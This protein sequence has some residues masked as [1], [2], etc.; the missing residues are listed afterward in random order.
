MAKAK[1]RRPSDCKIKVGEKRCTGKYKLSYD[2]AAPLFTCNKCQDRDTSWKKFYDDYLQL[3]SVKENWD[4]EKNNVTCIIGF[5]CHM[6]RELFDTDYVFVPNN[7]NP[8]SSKEIREAWKLL[9]TFKNDVIQV[10]KYIYWVFRKNIRRSTNL[11][12]FNYIN[13][14]GLIRRY[15]LHARNKQSIARFTALPLGFLYK[16]RADTPDIF[17]NYELTTVN[18]LGALLSHVKFYDVDLAA[19]EHQVIKIAET[20]GLIKDS[21]LNIK[22]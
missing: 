18:D 2:N 6:Y 3:Y 13:A 16:C 17:D 15:N 20:F 7:P 10:R 4:V 22:D 14:P 21:Q 9:A 8:Y 5:F 1:K 12:S 11:V 19:P